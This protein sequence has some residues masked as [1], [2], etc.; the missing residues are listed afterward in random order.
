[1]NSNALEILNLLL[2]KYERSSHFRGTATTNRKV[3]LS[4]H[5]YEHYDI[6]NADKKNSVHMTLDALEK[7]KLLHIKWYK[8][9][10]GNIIDYIY[11][12]LDNI[13]RVYTAAKREPKSALL[14]SRK[15]S[16]VELSKKISLY[17]IKAFI[18]DTIEVIDTSK[19]LPSLI[20]DDDSTF[21]ILLD[22]LYGIDQQ[23]GNELFERMFSRKYLGG[24]KV[25][26][27]RIR[28]KI[29]SIAKK[30]LKEDYNQSNN[31]IL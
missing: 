13:D 28:S 21:Q 26:E 19:T 22:T 31:E 14:S 30:Y 20:S 5:E 8:Y 1:M 18:D 4:L 10:K 11:L 2:D 7:K 9:Q 3:K 12:N 23:N 15:T 17:W 16:L 27:Q 29:I 24:S 25:F 6:E